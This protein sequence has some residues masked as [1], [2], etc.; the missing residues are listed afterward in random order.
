VS[1]AY[2]II[3]L[4]EKAEGRNFSIFYESFKK[5]E[6]S[7]LEDLKSLQLDKLKKLITHAYQ[8]VPYYKE[9]FDS[10][11]FNP[12]DLK[13]LDDIKQIPLLSKEQLKSNYSSLISN[14]Y[15]PSQLIEY[16][17]GGSSGTPTNFLLTKEQYDSRTAVSFKAY[18]MAGWDFMRKTLFLSGAPIESSKDDHFREK[19]K[20]FL[21]RRYTIP[22]FD[23]NE[24][25]LNDI[26]HYIKRKKPSVIFGYVS[27]LL[28]FAQ[29]I[30]ENNIDIKIPTIVQ[31]AEMIYPDQ[32][33]YI[34]KYL[35]GKF[36]RHYGARDAIAMGIECFNRNGLHANMDTL[37]IE[38]LKNNKEILEED[39]EIFITDLYSFGMPLIRYQIGD[40]GK[41]KRGICSCGR[42]SPLFE[43]TQG[44]KT[45]IISTKDGTFM[46]G[47]FIPHLFKE[48]SNKINQYQVIQPDIESLVVRIV[49]RSEY[50]N[51]D[52]EYLSNKLKEK[53]GKE[54]DIKF[55]YPIYIPPEPS[56]K[57]M[58]VKSHV[59]ISF[60]NK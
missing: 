58:F 14:S 55:E 49:K 6:F 17:T 33:E 15:N 18:Q 51:A 2:H 11:G 4:Y 10:I 35:N 56:G 44:R 5:S 38:I 20:S 27:S 7:S 29:Y 28:L 13:T 32:I 57:Y 34:E 52:E 42:A 54:I 43:I 8:T 25:K 37:F 46:T 22:T 30:E 31:M 47:L 16:A 39:G 19:L 23:L 9:Q 1:I 24:N 59:P 3:R 53:L 41:W 48:L 50:V 12:G 45:N 26:Y 21:M 60:G 36:F 40:V